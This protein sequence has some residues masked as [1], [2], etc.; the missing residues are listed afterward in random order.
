MKHM[1]RKK[2]IYLIF[3]ELVAK[4]DQAANE[5]IFD[6]QGRRIIDFIYELYTVEEFLSDLQ[7]LKG[8]LFRCTK[9]YIGTHISYGTNDFEPFFKIIPSICARK[10]Y[11]FS[12]FFYDFEK[13]K[14]KSL[15]DFSLT[16]YAFIGALENYEKPKRKI[17]VRDNIYQSDNISN[18][19]KFD[20]LKINFYRMKIDSYEEDYARLLNSVVYDFKLKLKYNSKKINESNAKY[21]KR[22]K[23]YDAYVDQV[24]G[25]YGR[26]FAIS[27]DFW[28][29]DDKE[30]K[31]GELK[32]FF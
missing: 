5:I 12:P 21:R 20:F 18:Y 16:L 3:Q 23:E 15:R 29:E 8:D 26:V 2:E 4:Y 30:L 17:S 1:V 10:L 11:P 31:I 7:F 9:K 13:Y 27:L 24:I 22:K 6:P 25:E 14:E 19:V 28:C 32:N